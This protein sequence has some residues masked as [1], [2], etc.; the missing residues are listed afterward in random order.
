MNIQSVAVRGPIFWI[1]AGLL[2]LSRACVCA[3]MCV[4]MLLTC[5]Q[6]LGE[7]PRHGAVIQQTLV[8]WPHPFNLC[9]AVMMLMMVTQA[10][11]WDYVVLMFL[12]FQTWPRCCLPSVYVN[13]C[14]TKKSHINSKRHNKLLLWD[15][16][17][18]FFISFFF[19]GA[20]MHKNYT[21]GKRIE[22][23]DTLRRSK[24]SHYHDVSVEGALEPWL[25]AE[26]LAAVF[27]LHG[28]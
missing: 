24:S 11:H 22:S 18:F 4:W 28:G 10:E 5:F 20:K 3:G 14:H 27:S 12:F 15:Y 17:L 16:G 23:S 2:I 6:S 19:V 8:W 26:Q 9:W 7:C 1:W 13:S 25:Q 21:V